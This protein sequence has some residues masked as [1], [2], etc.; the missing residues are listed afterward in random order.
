MNT[1]Y[2][3]RKN[4]KQN[5]TRK[6]KSLNC[7]PYIKNKTPLDHT[8]LSKE[9]LEILKNSFN[10]RYKDTPDK[11]IV[12]NTSVKIWENLQEKIPSCEKETCWLNLIPDLKLKNKMQEHFFAPFQPNEWKTNPNAWLSNYDILNVLT[13]YEKAHP[14]FLFLGPSPIDFDSLNNKQCVWEELCKLS[15]LK[16]YE[17][18]KRQIGIIFNLDKHNEPGSHWVSMFIDLEYNPKPFIFYFDSTS[19]PIPS[20]IQHLKNRILQQWQTFPYRKGKM[21][22]YQNNRTKHQLYNTEC[23]M[24]SLF[25]LI[26]L[27]SRELRDPDEKKTRSLSFSQI[28]K[29]F[30]GPKR[31]SDK[32]MEKFRGIYFNS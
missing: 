19:I 30:L 31:I 12:E 2:K 32:Q 9:A 22:F 17:N 10:E 28:L 5:K 7:S 15:I 25:F 1:Y 21:Y 13:Q 26:T 16:E 20:R 3:K 29:I 23:G 18:G 6:F 27:L 8:C 14:S 24:Y 11:Q 4:T